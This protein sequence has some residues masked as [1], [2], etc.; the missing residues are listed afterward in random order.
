[1][2]TEAGVEV[3]VQDTE[4]LKRVYE[5]PYPKTWEYIK[6]LIDD[7]ENEGDQ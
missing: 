7:P 5:E 2:L 4:K 3:I 6:Q 1:M